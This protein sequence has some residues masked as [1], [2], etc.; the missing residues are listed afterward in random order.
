M[1]KVFLFS[2]CLSIFCAGATSAQSGCYSSSSDDDA[3]LK[4][5]R[6]IDANHLCEAIYSRLLKRAAKCVEGQIVDGEDM[7]INAKLNPSGDMKRFDVALFGRQEYLAHAAGD[8]YES[9]RF[10]VLVFL[11]LECKPAFYAVNHE[12]RY[13]RRPYSIAISANNRNWKMIDPGANDR[14]RDLQGEIIQASGVAFYASLQ[15]R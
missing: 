11:N 9:H 12:P 1:R 15:S 2:L 7:H 13:I 4:M 3:S 14:L 5:A 6:Q 10:V 8:G